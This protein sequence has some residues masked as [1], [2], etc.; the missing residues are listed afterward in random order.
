MHRFFSGSVDVAIQKDDINHIVNVLRLRAG[1]EITICDTNA[2]E[3][4]CRIT[5]LSKSSVGVEVV[6]SAPNK[7]EPRVQVTLFQ[8]LPKSDKMDLIVQKCVELG[9]NCIVPVECMRSIAKIADKADKKIVRWQSISES[10]AKQS[11]RGIVP[12]IGDVLSFSEAVQQMQGYDLALMPYELESSESIRNTIESAVSINDNIKTLAIFIGPEGGISD[13]E[14]D[15]AKMHGIKTVS[16][17]KRILRCETAGFSA[18]T[19]ALAFLGE[20]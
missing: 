20:Y 6:S 17:G 12:T 3:H 1:D 10:A 9:V 7:C 14:A 13:E 15:L 5:E 18:L 16:L 4:L 8:G 19:L 2:T 11:G